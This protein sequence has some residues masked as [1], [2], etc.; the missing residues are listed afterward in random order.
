[1]C[2]YKRVSW[3]FVLLC[4]HQL[5]N[6]LH[7]GWRDAT[8]EESGRDRFDMARIFGVFKVGGRENEAPAGDDL[9]G[10]ILLHLSNADVANVLNWQVDIV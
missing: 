4:G 1:M 3:S 7:V 2:K 5:V 8:K 9:V 10:W 6:P